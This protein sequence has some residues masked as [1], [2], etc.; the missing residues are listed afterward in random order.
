MNRAFI[1]IGHIGNLEVG[2]GVGYTK[3]P[4]GKPFCLYKLFRNSN[5]FLSI[6]GMVGTLPNDKFPDTRQELTLSADLL[7][8]SSWDYLT[9]LHVCFR[10]LSVHTLT[11]KQM[12]VS[13]FKMR[14][15]LRLTEVACPRSQS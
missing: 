14:R 3:I 13:L 15:K 9:L 8:G 12:R 10:C 1:G 2:D 11:G 7:N 4:E 5:T 6:L